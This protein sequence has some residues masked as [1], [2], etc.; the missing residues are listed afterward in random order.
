MIL[1]F[2]T[3]FLGFARGYWSNFP[4]E[5]FGHHVHMFS[6][7]AWFALVMSQPYLATRGNLKAHRRNGLIGLFVAGLVVASAALMM[8]ATYFSDCNRNC[9]SY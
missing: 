3:V 2:I 4:N 5:T 6:A 1:V 7:L 9:I 8:P